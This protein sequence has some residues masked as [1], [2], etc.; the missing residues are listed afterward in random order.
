[1]AAATLLLLLASGGGRTY[2]LRGHG[3]AGGKM[4]SAASVANSGDTLCT[5]THV[6]MNLGFENSS[7][8]VTP[9]AHTP[10]SSTATVA[11]SAHQWQT[12]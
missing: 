2:D 6:K 3:E 11:H 9:P 5:C 1:M 8:D 7:W 12:I 10:M 4:F